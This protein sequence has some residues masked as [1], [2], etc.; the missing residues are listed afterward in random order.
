[1][2]PGAGTQI[3]QRRLRRRRSRRGTGKRH[4]V[5][6]RWAPRQRHDGNTAASA[7]SWIDACCRGVCCRDE[8]GVVV[9][10]VVVIFIGGGGGAPVPPC[11]IPGS[12]WC[13][14]PG[15]C[16]A[17]RE[18]AEPR[19]VIERCDDTGSIRARCAD[20]SHTVGH[21]PDHAL[22][23]LPSHHTRIWSR[24]RWHLSF[25][26]FFYFSFVVATFFS[27]GYTSQRPTSGVLLA[28]RCAGPLVVHPITDAVEPVVAR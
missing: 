27:L 2:Q 23:P 19:L 16:Q 13:V 25:F 6:P 10:V 24:T 12:C 3:V 7:R 15:R 20:R 22:L 8:R 21:R 5:E 17:N 14:G 11:F 26:F 18:V 4:L 1:L 28:R 9:V